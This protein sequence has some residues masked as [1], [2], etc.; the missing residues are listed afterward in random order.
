MFC[1]PLGI[2]DHNTNA[3]L[4]MVCAVVIFSLCVILCQLELTGF[5]YNAVDLECKKQHGLA[6]RLFSCTQ[7]ESTNQIKAESNNSVYIYISTSVFGKCSCYSNLQLLAGLTW[8][9][10]LCGS[11]QGHHAKPATKTPWFYCIWIEVSEHWG[12]C[13]AKALSEI[14]KARESLMKL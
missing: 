3:F 6:C 11:A 2:S 13:I 14:G 1:D 8:W 10:H 4:N 9:H 5:T 7:C 12:T